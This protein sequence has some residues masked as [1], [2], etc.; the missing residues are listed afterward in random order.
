[1][2][3]AELIDLLQRFA[4]AL[5]IGFLMGI[6]R[7]FRHRDAPE[8][9]RAAGLRTHALIGLLGGVGGALLPMVGQVGFAALT[10]AFA[11]ALI[12]FKVRESMADNDLSVTG[13]IAAL[14]LFALGAYAMWADLRV[15]AAV[16]VALVGLL[17]VKDALHDPLTLGLDHG[18]TGMAFALEDWHDRLP[19]TR[20]LFGPRP[21]FG[22]FLADFLPAHG[23]P[24]DRAHWF[25]GEMHGMSV[26]ETLGAMSRAPTSPAHWNLPSTGAGPDGTRT[27][28][29]RA[30]FSSDLHLMP[31]VVYGILDVWQRGNG[32]G[33]MQR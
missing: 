3:D 30:P 28:M 32:F 15:V 7:G 24:A 18:F 27:P 6:E 4:M 13:T 8:G 31:A 11:V 29:F 12:V 10:L 33:R 21:T 26:Q 20:Q 5:G 16:G 14:A 25:A 1:M 22:E 2:S 9:A 17:A 19:L 23:I